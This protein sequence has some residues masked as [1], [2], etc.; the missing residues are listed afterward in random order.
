MNIIVNDHLWTTP[1]CQQRPAWSNNDQPKYLLLLI[2]FRHPS[3]Q[4]TLSSGPEGGRCSQVWLYFRL[5]C[6]TWRWGKVRKG[7]L[8]EYIRRSDC[9]ECL[10]SQKIDYQYI[11][12]S[13][14]VEISLTRLY[15]GCLKCLNKPGGR[16]VLISYYLKMHES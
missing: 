14:L 8:L 12:V 10:K 6:F 9:S 11:K 2:F 5:P 16:F 3:A 1:S 4:Q 13:S 15:V 7:R